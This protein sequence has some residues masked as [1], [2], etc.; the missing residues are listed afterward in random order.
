[1]AKPQPLPTGI[2]TGPLAAYG[3]Y[4]YTIGSDNNLYKLSTTVAI[5]DGTAVP[6]LDVSAAVGIQYITINFNTNTNKKEMYISAVGEIGN[7]NGK[8]YLIPDLDNPVL[9]IFVSGIDSPR[10]LQVNN[11]YLYVVTITDSTPL[12]IAKIFQFLLTNSAS[13]TVLQL[14]PG[15]FLGA[16]QLVITGDNLYI[17][18]SATSYCYIAKVSSISTFSS[19]SIFNLTWVD[20]NS[21]PNIQAI[22]KILVT[23]G[24][25]LYL[26]IIHRTQT[27][28][29]IWVRLILI[30]QLFKM[31]IIFLILH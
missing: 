31:I 9:T 4:V 11:G 28:I 10:G 21:F 22:D 12:F 13:Q 25:Y 14:T 20:V 7:G 1:M 3:G 30:Q 19:S 27:I 26:I 6:I 8:I 5:P 29:T 18:N 17:I 24:T 23:D 15:Q 2:Q 16:Q